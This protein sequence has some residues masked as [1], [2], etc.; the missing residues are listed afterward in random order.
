[1]GFFFMKYRNKYNAEVTI[2]LAVTVSLTGAGLA[3]LVL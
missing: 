1:M 2:K 3:Q